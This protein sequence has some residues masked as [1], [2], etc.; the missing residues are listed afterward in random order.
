VQGRVLASIAKALPKVLAP[1]PRYGASGYLTNAR[2]V[3]SR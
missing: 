3:H 1:A 2:R